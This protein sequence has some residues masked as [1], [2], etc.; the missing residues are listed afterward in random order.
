MYYIYLIQNLINLKIYIGF[1]KNPKFRWTQHISI[2]KRKTNKYPLYNAIR[3]Y[4][5][6]HFAM[7]TIES[8][9]NIEEALEAEKFW[10]EYFKTNITKYGSEYGYNLTEGGE[11][12]SGRTHSQK[13]KNKISKSLIG[14][15][16]N[17]GN[18][19]SSETRRK[20][21]IVHIGEKNAKAKLTA[22]DVIA[23]RNY[24]KNNKNISKNIFKELLEIYQ[25]YHLS[26]SG[27]EKIIYRKTWKHIS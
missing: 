5:K 10:I 24:H 13:T 1:S 27:L 21:S 17:L 20:M 8:F 6:K 9:N 26:I 16:Y 2:A 4:G 11:G 18:K 23:I 12:T 19:A 3:K 25:K 14:N 22:Q 15:K 7:H